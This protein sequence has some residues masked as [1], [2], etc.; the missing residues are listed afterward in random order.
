M[1]S[2]LP[3]GSWPSPISPADL[4]RAALGLSPGLIVDGVRYWTE[5]HPEQGGRVGLWRR[6]PGEA[7]VELT[8]DA[9]V[10]TGVNEYGGGAWTA[11]AGLVAYSSW[12]DGAVRLIE[13]GAVRT[14]APGAPYRYAALELDPARRLLLAVR[15]DHSAAGAEAVT[16][17]V[18]LDL[19]SDNAEGGTVL[20]AGA[21]F[22]AHPRLSADGRLAW[23]EWNHPDMPWDSTRVVV[24]PLSDPTAR[25]VVG[26]GPEISALYP[27]WAPDGGLILLDDASGYWNFQRWSADSGVRELYPAPYDFCG[28]LWV[29]TP[30][31]YTVIDACRIG[32]TWLVEGVSQVGVLEFDPTGADP[33][34]LDEIATGAVTA[35]VAGTGEETLALLGYPDRPAELVELHWTD[36]SI[37]TVR[38]SSGID[39]PAAVVSRA[40][41]FCWEGPQGPVYAWFYP[42]ANG[43]LTGLPGELPPVQVW[44]HGGPSAYSGPDFAVSVQFWTSRGIGILDVNYGGSTGYGRAYRERLRGNWGIVDVRDCVESVR[45]LAHAGLADDARL[46]IRGGSAGGYTTLAALTGS[47][48]FAAG[49]SLYGIGDLEL[50]ATDPTGSGQVTHKFESRYLDG[51]VAP[52]PEGRETYRERSPIHHLDRLSCPMLILQGADDMVVPPNQ[53]VAMAAAVRAK[54]LP[55]ELVI[56]EGEGHGFRRAENIIATADHALAFLG[57]VHGF[58]PA[59][60]S[61]GAL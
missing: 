9:Y 12:P 46:S 29:L 16:T 15:E 40:R 58:T 39:I 43:D 48:V 44:S 51:L 57:H 35:E 7:A 24:A 27:S 25:T 6:V 2:A 23:C 54:G 34:H 11:G 13:D 5:G 17:I 10:R 22:Y 32:C 37:R 52:Y 4:T 1:S 55:V 26:G 21:D 42:P 49:I 36:G 3:Y 59:A 45:A 47:D 31:P 60:D 38:R 28:P 19:D 18:A 56:F 20:V 14:I 50:L 8:P 33:G 61:P 30:V 53:A 41:P